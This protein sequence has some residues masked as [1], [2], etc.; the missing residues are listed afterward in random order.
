MNRRRPPGSGV[1]SPCES[2]SA[3]DV[4]EWWKYFRDEESSFP[5]TP[6]PFIDWQLLAKEAERMGLYQEP[7]FQ[8]KVGIF[9]KVRSLLLLKSEEI[10]AKINLTPEMIRTHYEQEYCPQY[11]V[12]LLFFHDTQPA[13]QATADLRS[14]RQ[15][16]E[17]YKG[18]SN[19]HGG[20]VYYQE[21]LLRPKKI[22]PDWLQT[23][24]A[25]QEGDISSPQ[26]WK[27][28]YVVFHLLSKITFDEAD[29]EKQKD[30]VTRELRRIQEAKLTAVLVNELKEKYHVQVNEEL[31]AALD[32]YDIDGASADAV[33]ITTSKGDITVKQFFEQV[34]KQEKFFKKFGSEKVEREQ[35]KQRVLNNILS[36]TMTSW[37]ALDRHYEERPPLQEVYQFYKQHRLIKELE[38]R[39][40]EPKSDVNP[41]EVEAY[42]RQHE[43]EFTQPAKVHIASMEYSGQ[44]IDRIWA[45][46]TTGNDFGKVAEKY[47]GRPLIEAEQLAEQLDPA[48]KEVVGKLGPGEISPPFLN[49]G[50]WLLVKLINNRKTHVEPLAEVTNRISAKLQQEKFD[51]AR[52]TFLDLLKTKVSI[53]VNDSAW[54]ALQADMAE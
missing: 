8:R 42:Y 15:T 34:R 25:M 28:G 21:R 9:L 47:T 26:P 14:G 12:E 54:Q 23:V 41:G 19:I 20:E 32:P 36:Q 2:Y 5:E 35:L 53:T 10:D 18:Q 38:K 37:A 51:Q 13:E 49:N 40:F 39:L 44:Q 4:K 22:N 24:A 3:Q 46:I 6:G 50:H 31:F 17:Y 11:Q 48:L 45:E 1:I 30:A 33:L 52:A 7:S 16:M 27:E 29:F 43:E